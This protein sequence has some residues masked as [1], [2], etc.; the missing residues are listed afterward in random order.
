MKREVG[1]LQATSINMIDMVG[2]GPFVT[3][4]LVIGQMGSHFLYAWL[5]GALIS[6]IDAFI[7]SELG[8]AFPKAGGSY[9]FLR[10][11]YG[12]KYGRLLS[13]LYVWQT[14]VQAPLVVASGAIGFSHYATYLFE[15][16]EWERKFLSGSVVIVL[17]MLLYREIKTIGVISVILWASVV[18]T[19]VAIIAAGFSYPVP[20]EGWL[21]SALEWPDLSS[22]F[23]VALGSASVKTVYSYLGYYNVC[24]LGGEIKKPERNIPISIFLSVAGITVL[25]L[26]LNLSIVRVIPWQEAQ[27]SSFIA[28]DLIGKVFG[29]QSGM[30]ATALVLLIAFSSLFAVLLGYSRIPYAAAVDGQFFSVFAKLH[31][32]KNFPYVSLLA[33]GGIAFVFSLLFKLKDVITAVLA[34]RI[35]VQ[36]IGQAIG[37]MALRYRTGGTHLKYR[38]PLYPL[39]AVLAIAVWSYIFYSTGKT[40]MISGGLMMMLGLMIYYLKER[41]AAKPLPHP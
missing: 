41:A 17:V 16:N 22:L 25:Y 21:S 20:A 2:I 36:F 40:F 12:K 33:L 38:V 30:I 3:I 29:R 9:N 26:L 1:L 23:F 14:V 6:F 7:W 31:P 15:M 5:L 18:I 37:L 19:L 24:H 8:S 28:S 34:M 13:F 35:V 39:P 32:T 10:E 4:P 27:H 11:A